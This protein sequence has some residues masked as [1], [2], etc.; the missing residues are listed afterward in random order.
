MGGEASA[1]LACSPHPR[2]SH[3]ARIPVQ[4]P[5]CDVSVLLLI[6]T[7]SFSLGS[8]LLRSSWCLSLSLNGFLACGH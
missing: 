5:G 3:Q 6:T 2:R 4:N 1:P 8:D 7:L